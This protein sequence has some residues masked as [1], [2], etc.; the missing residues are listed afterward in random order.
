MAETWGEDRLIADGFGRVLVELDWYDGLR[1]GLAEIDG[2]VHYFESSNYVDLVDE[3]IYY[4]WPAT[5]QVAALEREQWA[6]YV[7]WN[8]RYEA[9]E[10]WPGNHPGHRGVDARYDE[11]ESLLTPH[12]QAPADARPLQAEW[13]FGPG[14]R[15]QPEGIDTWVRWSSSR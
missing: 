15:Y 8:R 9:G 11:L 10:A 1:A 3:V 7:E 13:R 2:T 12:R 14:N 5:D 4:V 6:I